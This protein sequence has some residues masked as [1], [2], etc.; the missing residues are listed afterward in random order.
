M[1]PFSGALQYFSIFKRHVGR[2]IYLIFFL[3]VL[4]GAAEGVGIT[5]LLPLL[6]VL[7]MGGPHESGLAVGILNTLERFGFGASLLNILVLIAAVFLL[8]GLL[9]FARAVYTGVVEARLLHEMRSRLFD[10]YSGMDYLYY[11]RG[12]TGHFVNIIKSQTNQ[13]FTAFS[14]FL[15]FGTKVITS[16]IYLAIAVTLAWRFGVMA[17]GLGAVLLLLFRQLNDWIRDLSRLE[18][19]ESSHLNKLLV[20]S[21][22]AFKYLASTNQMA[23]LGGAIETSIDRLTSFHIRTR[24]AAAFTSGITEPVSVF[25]ILSILVIQVSVLEQPVAPILV[26]TVLFYRGVN[27]VLSIQTTWQ[28]VLS[29]IGAVELIRDEL[30][31]LD[32]HREKGGTIQVGAINDSIQFRGVN[33]A[34]S[35]EGGD[36]L[37]DVSLTIPAR[38]TVAFVGES[39][40]GKSTMVDLLTL[41]LKP[42]RGE[43]LINGINGSDVDLPSWRS[44]I[45]Y[46][47]QDTVVFDDT[48]AGNIALG[49]SK[50]ANVP[51]VAA[52]VREAAARANIAKFIEQLPD[53][54]DTVVGERGVRLSGGQRQRLFIAR[55][56]YKRPSLL[57]LDEATSALDTESERAVQESID[58]LH[59]EMT[60]VMIAHRLSTIRNADRVYVLERGRVV[61]EG[62]YADLRDQADSRFHRMV[63]LQ[64]I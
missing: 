45:G 42:N 44:Q 43:I 25:F 19:R 16:T 40:A 20:Q 59:G 28:R 39:G 4:A 48:I 47:S 55:E 7:Q 15:A 17:M 2:R 5:L 23:H 21:L 26:A 12:D 9:L 14:S 54:Y 36:V 37:H 46:V 57:I 51:D 61:E 30:D 49:D 38:S 32:A 13:F 3:S 6:A 11:V 64:A 63:S 62:P 27:S 41:L 1:N 53:G 52:R 10:A 31:A 8:K 35:T 60:V 24:V 34:Y 18:A 50:G 29:S 58:A 56:L 33:F 22:Q